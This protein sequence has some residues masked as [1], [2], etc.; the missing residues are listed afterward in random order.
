[1]DLP[2]PLYREYALENL[3]KRSPSF[4]YVQQHA[5][6]ERSNVADLCKRFTSGSR[7]LRADDEESRPGNARD[8]KLPDRTVMFDRFNLK[9]GK[10]KKRER[11]RER[12]RERGRESMTAII[13]QMKC[14]KCLAMSGTGKNWKHHQEKDRHIS[15]DKREKRESN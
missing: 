6:V 14:E 4:P 15:S 1:M 8:E 2:E 11:E 10:K 13:S 3:N 5:F 12:E 7:F 9:E